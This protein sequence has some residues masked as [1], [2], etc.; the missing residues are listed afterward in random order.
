MTDPFARRLTRRQLI[1]RAAAGG[2]ALSLPSLLAAC[3]GDGIEGAGQQTKTAED[4]T[5]VEQVLADTLRFANWPLY[6]DVSDDEKTRPTLEQFTREFGVE[7]EYI[8]EI[9]DNEEYFGRIQAPLSQGQSIDRDLIVLTDFMAARLVDLGWLA[10]VDKNAIPN[11][12]NLLPNYQGVSWDP[13]R[14]YS[15]PWQGGMTGI[16]YNR[17]RVGFEITSIDQLLDE[18]SLRGRVTLLSEM[19]DTVPLVMLSQGNDPNEATAET[20]DQAIQRIRAAVDSGQVRQFTGN[21]YTGMLARGDV[22]AAM[23]WSGDV[24]QLQFENEALQFVLPESGG[25]LWADNMLIPNGGDVYTA[26]TFMN[27][28]YDP[29]VAAQIAAWVNYITPVVG[30]QEAMQEIDPELAENTLIFPD[31]EMLANVVETP[32]EFSNNEEYKEQFQALLGG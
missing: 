16:G 4:T 13:E 2:A 20:F 32:P 22:W 21:E 28:V 12:A 31:E 17:R 23:A 14:Q 24:I 18:P 3:G 19:G 30:A 25:N 29:E 15:L 7:V 6:I 5:T 26:S 10:Q 27:Y 11:A 9:N 1:R 8:E